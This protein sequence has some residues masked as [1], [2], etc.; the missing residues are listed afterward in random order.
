MHLIINSKSFLISNNVYNKV[1]NPLAFSYQKF[2]YNIF[3]SFVSYFF[4]DKFFL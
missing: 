4:K 3:I 1:F 2:I